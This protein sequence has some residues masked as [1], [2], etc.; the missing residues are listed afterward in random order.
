MIKVYETIGTAR[1]VTSIMVNGNPITITFAGGQLQPS[2]RRG[3]YRTNS[4]EIQ[5]A[6]EQDSA[7]GVEYR[8]K[9][10][11]AITAEPRKMTT[12]EEVVNRQTAIEWMRRELG[13]KLNIT[14]KSQRIIERAAENGYLF[15]NWEVK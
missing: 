10:E 4:L 12:V 8:L 14:T 3:T 5:Q 9:S 7:F 6:L 1:L 11:T 2:F 15:I 13:I